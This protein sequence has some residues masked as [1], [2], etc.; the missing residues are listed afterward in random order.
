[1][2]KVVRI[3]TALPLKTKRRIEKLAGSDD[4]FSEAEVIRFALKI[5]LDEMEANP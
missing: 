2:S 5:G 4:W 1:M 3:N